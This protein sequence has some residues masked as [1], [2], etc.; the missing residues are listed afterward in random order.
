[1]LSEKHTMNMSS[2]SV[3]DQNPENLSA[4]PPATHQ[5]QPNK[6][7]ET[8][9][10]ERRVKRGISLAAGYNQHLGAVTGSITDVLWPSSGHKWLVALL[11]CYND[12]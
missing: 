6:N 1:M 7:K 5:C 12:L 3:L 9:K 8:R 4:Q 2:L 10:K 11:L